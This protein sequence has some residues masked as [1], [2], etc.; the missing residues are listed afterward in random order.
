MIKDGLNEGSIFESLVQ[1]LRE[2]GIRTVEDRL[3]DGNPGFPVTLDLRD[4]STVTLD[5]PFP[6]FV[7]NLDPEHIGVAMLDPMG[8][9]RRTWGLARRVP[10]F[11]SPGSLLET[12]L[13]GLLEGSYQGAY[14]SIYLDG[15]RYLSGAVSAGAGT[16][17]FVLVVNANEE[18]QAKKQASKSWR[19]AKA[20]QRLGKA[21]TM[22]QTMQPLCIS[23]AHEIASSAEL[24]AV[25]LWINNPEENSL[26][27][28]AS[29]GA[30]RQAAAVLS[31]LAPTGGV[32]CIAELVADSR[33]PFFQ[34]DVLEHVITANLEAKF[35][36][37]KPK[38]VSVHPLVISDRLLGVIEFVGRDVDTHFE[39]NLELFE[40]IA[41]HLALALNSAMMFENF[42]KLA[43]H[44]ALTGIPNHRHLQEFLHQR[45]AEA[46]RTGQT[47]GVIMLDVDHF[48]AF[49]EE[50]GHDAGDAVLRLVAE[51]LKGSVRP[52]D[53]AARYGGEEFTIIMPGSTIEATA[54]A[55][56][57]IRKRIEE[58]PFHTRNGR[59]RQVTV[60]L[61]CA[62][63]PASGSDSASVLKA[64]DVALFGAKRAGR[65]RVTVYEGRLQ[66][67]EPSG[68]TL[69]ELVRKKVPKTDLLAAT[70][71][72]AVCE[73]IV[74]ELARL[75]PLSNRQKDMLLALL[76]T[77]PTYRRMRERGDED[78]MRTWLGKE[79]MRPLAPSLLGL[80]ERFDGQGRSGVPGPRIPLLSRILT[81]LLAIAEE[82]GDALLSDKGRY[83]PEIVTLV[84][85][86][87]QAA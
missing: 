46:E 21:L 83:D 1:V 27:L 65:N 38:G 6:G 3:V 72:N 68:P 30:N 33:Q 43:T 85:D 82:A 80:E 31:K 76:W 84:T 53:L 56:E 13:Q 49:N 32:T 52:Y 14:G 39:E 86:A 26:D 36:Y 34:G 37:L 50:E 24:A 42:E 69:L 2:A 11:R 67:D 79:E 55:A 12:Q 9:V 75:L 20:L 22:N 70:A 29:V 7:A 18:K 77:V 61:G 81:V 48:R 8:Y 19:M 40:T 62:T 5:L 10:M 73:P 74:D 59:E 35:C 41:E 71:L 64:A 87:Q 63:Y 16:D 28:V 17:V 78:S 23:A 60:S 44:D 66:K 4:G 47:I 54:A 51:A 57:R 25:L 58:T 45:V 15:F